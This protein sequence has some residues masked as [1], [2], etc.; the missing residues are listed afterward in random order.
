MFIATSRTWRTYMIKTVSSYCSFCW[1]SLLLPHLLHLLQFV[2]RYALQALCLKT[3]YDCMQC[4][5]KPDYL[6]YN[7]M[8]FSRLMKGFQFCFFFF[9]TKITKRLVICT[10]CLNSS[11][12]VGSF[13]FFFSHRLLSGVCVP[14]YDTV[15]CCSSLPIVSR[16]HLPQGQ[17][18]LIHHVKMVSIKPAY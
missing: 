18:P 14:V 3:I 10:Y 9:L 12:L 2:L 6:L 5:I 16:I 1:S 7:F 15:L 17:V 13:W 11:S 4:T 8:Y